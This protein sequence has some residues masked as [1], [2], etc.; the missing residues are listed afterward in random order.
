[1]FFIFNPFFY[2]NHDNKEY[3]PLNLIMLLKNILLICFSAYQLR[4][5]E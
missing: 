5:N 2:Q 1:M 3:F 4:A